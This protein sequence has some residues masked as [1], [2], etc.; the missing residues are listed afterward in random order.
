M[1]IKILAQAAFDGTMWIMGSD[2]ADVI[3]QH[4]YT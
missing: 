4:I 2:S 1:L 3:M